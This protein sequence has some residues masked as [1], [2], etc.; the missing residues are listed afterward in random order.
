M[1]GH[2]P[3]VPRPG[4]AGPSTG[5]VGGAG[6]SPAAPGAPR[7]FSLAPADRLTRDARRPPSPPRASALT[8]PSDITGTRIIFARRGKYPHIDRSR[9]NFMQLLHC[10][11]PSVAVLMIAACPR[12]QPR[13]RHSSPLSRFSEDLVTKRVPTNRGLGNL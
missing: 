7:H 2:G 3:R 5:A 13:R 10:P 4:W 8:T 6:A 11:S 9:L 12:R 1:V